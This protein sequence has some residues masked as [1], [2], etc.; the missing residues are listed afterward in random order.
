MQSKRE[1]LCW[2]DDSGKQKKKKTRFVPFNPINVG[3]GSG[4]FARLPLNDGLHCVK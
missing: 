4:F 1:P 3:G 2:E